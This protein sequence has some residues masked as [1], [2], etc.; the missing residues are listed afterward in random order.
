MNPDA[1]RRHASAVRRRLDDERDTEP[2]SR[3]LDVPSR[4]A[5]T[6]V[7]STASIAESIACSVCGKP[8]TATR[9]VISF[10]TG[11]D[12]RMGVAH[13]CPDC[14]RAAADAEIERYEREQAKHLERAIAK[15][16]A[17]FAQARV[18]DP[19]VRTW[20]DRQLAGAR[21]WLVMIGNVGTGKT[22]HA[23]GIW[24]EFAERDPR[25]SLAA[26]RES[27]LLIQLRPDGKESTAD[28]IGRAGSAALLLLDDAGVSKPTEWALEQLAEIIDERYVHGRRTIITTNLAWEDLEVRL[29]ARVTSRVAELAETI[30]IDGQDRRRA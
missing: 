16:P 4:L 13:T 25:T 18:E 2:E 29:G 20:L 6:K 3:A 8:F 14:V 17:R 21:D 19:E 15:I 28:L 23:W 5:P 12:L 26:W 1:I 24:R 22:H 11:R 9:R 27:E 7:A 30:F 10:A